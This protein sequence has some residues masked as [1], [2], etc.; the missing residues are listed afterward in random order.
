M[1]KQLLLL[2]SIIWGLGLWSQTP[3]FEFDTY[4]YDEFY[5]SVIPLGNKAFITYN[6]QYHNHSTNE[7]EGFDHQIIIDQNGNIL[8]N[9][10]LDT[11]MA[12]GHNV[13]MSAII[14]KDSFIYQFGYL[15]SKDASFSRLFIRK[16][17]MNLNLIKDTILNF[18]NAFI[19]PT[20]VIWDSAAFLVGGNLY[21]QDTSVAIVLRITEDFQILNS[22]SIPLQMAFWYDVGL[23]SFPTGEL[24]LFITSYYQH[25]DLMLRIDRQTLQITDTL[26]IRGFDPNYGTYEYKNCFGSFLNDSILISPIDIFQEVYPLDTLF[27]LV[28]WLIWDRNGNILDTL[29][30]YRDTIMADRIGIRKTMLIHNDTIVM[31]YSHNSVWFT[32]DTSATF[33]LIFADLQGNPY[34]VTYFGGGSMSTVENLIRFDNGNYL[35]L[36]QR[37]KPY[38]A[39]PNYSFGLVG[40][41]LNSQGDVIQNIEFPK[42]QPA[43]LKI[44]PNPTTGLSVIRCEQPALNSKVYIEVYDMTGKL[45]QQDTKQLNLDTFDMD[46]YDLPAG[47]YHLIIK[48][49]NNNIHR[50]KIVKQ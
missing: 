36:A 44:F 15:I 17:D 28:G 8:L 48:E 47:I 32:P 19:S 45:V 25:N 21:S 13:G 34:R 30:P 41:L 10:L 20:D 14:Q 49:T 42:V 9:K 35:V 12:Y 22:L 33:A 37:S 50:G 5:S 6:S 4:K 24:N 43:Q 26:H 27:K 7:H 31:A 3:I 38:A 46:L 1:K 11:S 23:Y 40:Y 39:Q 16:T 18:N 2:L 29:M